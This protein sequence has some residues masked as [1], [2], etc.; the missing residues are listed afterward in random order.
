MWSTEEELMNPKENILGSRQSEH[1]R[2]A[3]AGEIREIVGR[4]L[5]KLHRGMLMT[6]LV[7]KN[8]Y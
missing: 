2:T 1:C 6:Y 8:R 4:R 3:G 7:L 5:E